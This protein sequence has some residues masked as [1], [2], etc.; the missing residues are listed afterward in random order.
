[1]AAWRADDYYMSRLPGT[2]VWH[3]TIQLRRGSRFQYWLSP[4]LRAG[5]D[6]LFTDQPDPLNPRVFSEDPNAGDLSSVLDTPG[7]PDESWVRRI[8][9][10]AD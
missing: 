10:N 8:P 3:K 6:R 7:A 1:M 2:D 9:T 5:A 4:N